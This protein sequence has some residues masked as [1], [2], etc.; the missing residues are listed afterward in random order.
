LH[1][2]LVTAV[3]LTPSTQPSLAFAPCTPAGKL[4]GAHVISVQVRPAV[5][6]SP[7]LIPEGHKRVPVIGVGVGIGVGRGLPQM[8]HPAVV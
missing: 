4:N 7:A 2:E 8:V 3:K 5:G 1:A 6:A